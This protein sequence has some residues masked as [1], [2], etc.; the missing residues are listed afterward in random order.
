MESYS[1]NKFSSIRCMF[2]KEYGL[3]IWLINE[4]FFNSG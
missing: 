3:K 1:E 4:G 2:S